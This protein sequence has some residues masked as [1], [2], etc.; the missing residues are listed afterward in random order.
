M[1]KYDDPNVIAGKQFYS[2]NPW[3]DGLPGFREAV[4]HYMSLVTGLCKRIDKSLVA[5]PI[6]D[7]DTLDATLEY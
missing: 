5:L 7:T 6:H 2:K 1:N 3:P 4:E